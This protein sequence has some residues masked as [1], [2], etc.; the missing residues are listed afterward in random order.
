MSASGSVWVSGFTFANVAKTSSIAEAWE[1]VLE[2]TRT[3][4]L[5][6]PN[7]TLHL[8]F[9]YYLLY[10]YVFILVVAAL[11][12]RMPEAW[13]QYLRDKFRQL[14]IRPIARI[15]LPAVITAITLLPMG[16]ILSTE[17]GFIPDLAV[18]VAYFVF[19]GFGWLLYREHEIVADFGRGAWLMTIAATG[20]YIAFELLVLP[21]LTALGNESLV[22]SIQSVVNGAVVWTLFY[23]FTGLFVRYLDQP[24]ARIRYI[25]DASYWVYLVHLPCTIWIPGLLVGTDLSVWMRM[26]IV[27]TGTTAIGF[28]SYS[29]FVRST[30]I[31][32]VLNGRRYPRGLPRSADTVPQR[33]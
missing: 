3:A 17:P 16:G 27:L 19:F 20:F 2:L 14:V 23:G 28:V 10:F 7:S 33:A 18:F 22:M 15:A 21:S 12:R 26:L 11:C 31:G 29:L 25:V 6:V 5:Y 9:I 13:Q 24:S 32:R 4:A 8:W 30:W 1:A